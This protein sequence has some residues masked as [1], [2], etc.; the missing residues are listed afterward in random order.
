[1]LL[2]TW[3]NSAL[4]I[5][6][7]KYLILQVIY[8]IITYVKYRDYKFIL[9]KKKRIENAKRRSKQNKK[10]NKKISE[11]SEEASPS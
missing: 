7:V 2:E 6:K 8:F 9:Q 10:T 1:M 4:E 5:Q 3:R 11:K